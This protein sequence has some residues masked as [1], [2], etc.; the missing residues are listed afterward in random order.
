MTVSSAPFSLDPQL[1]R[2]THPLGELHLCTL[3]L[4]ND[5]RYPWVIMVPKKP[6]LAEI[7]DLEEADRLILMQEISLI[8]ERLQQTLTPHKLNIA[9]LG[10][11]VRQLH[12]H[13]IAREQTDPAWPG[14][15]WGIGE[16]EIY[17]EN[18]L[19]NIQ[20]IFTPWA[21]GNHRET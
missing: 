20:A 5:R 9:A 6:G 10:N 3:R 2:D 15:V 16:A 8:A 17:E 21:S 18:Q 14:P 12:I 7:I 4:M 13:I 19:N 1:A 11:Q